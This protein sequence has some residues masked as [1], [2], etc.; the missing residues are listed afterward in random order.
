MERRLAAIFA[1]DLAPFLLQEVLGDSRAIVSTTN[2]EK[3]L[4]SD[5]T[6]GINPNY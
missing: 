4:H 3:V 2:P 5:Q 6:H 1:A